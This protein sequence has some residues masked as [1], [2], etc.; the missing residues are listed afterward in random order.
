MIPNLTP[1]ELD[2]LVALECDDHAN[3]Q[4]PIAP[5][6]CVTIT[7]DWAVNVGGPCDHDDCTDR[8]KD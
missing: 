4:P 7:T 2:T 6:T 8:E 3:P 1:H 5:H